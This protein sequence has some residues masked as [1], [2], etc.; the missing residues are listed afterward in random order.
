MQ[1]L[2]ASWVVPVASPPLRQGRVAIEGGRV[3]W[4]GG[5]AGGP[6][7]PVTDLGSG[8]L[9]PG[10][11]NAHC[12][13]ELSHLAGV[14]TGGGYVPWIRRLVA[15]RRDEAAG[16]AREAAARAVH[17]LE[18]AG[19]CALGDVSNALDHLEPLARS[20]LTAVVFHELIGWDPAAAESI[21]A[22]ASARAAA[23]EQKLAGGRLTVRLAAHAPHSVSAELLRR[24]AARGGPAAIHLAESAAERDFL[25]DGTGQWPEFLAWRGLGHVRFVP[26][27]L[28][29]VR[30]AGAEGALH[31]ALVAAHCV[32][33]DAEDHRLLARHGVHVAVCPRSNA[34]LGVGTAPV[35][36]MLEAGVRLCVGTDS[37]AS[38]PS[39]DVMD[40][41][42]ALHRAF[43]ALDA[44]LLVRMATLGGAEALGSPSWERSR[45]ASARRSRSPARTALPPTPAGTWCRA[46]P[47]C[48]R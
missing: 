31:G 16:R 11:V 7:G 22:D 2:T 40:E 46:R 14:D 42:A 39:L 10:L 45:P 8:V 34:A 25:A 28:S 19:T 9:L 38:A 23:A 29:P 24:L 26:P 48:V 17:A 18:R 30:Y 12:H 21:L 43:P 44:A 32:Q 6:D 20:S 15:A 4:V 33:T 5:A 13:L 1:I 35:P 47:G 37:L 41:L 36:A 27:G 3:V